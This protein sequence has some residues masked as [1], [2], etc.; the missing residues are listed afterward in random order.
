[1]SHALERTSPKGQ[2]F[3]GY[4][5]KC[6]AVNLTLQ[7]A[8]APCPADDIVSDTNAMLSLMRGDSKQ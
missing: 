5:V 8:L 2:L 3:V 6:G 4:C 1:M 7:A